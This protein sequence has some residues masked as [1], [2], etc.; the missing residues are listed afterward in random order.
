MNSNDWFQK[1]VDG[2]LPIESFYPVLRGRHAEDES[3]SSDIAIPISES[4]EARFIASIPEMNSYY[5]MNATG[6]EKLGLTREGLCEAAISNLWALFTAHRDTL[7]LGELLDESTEQP[8]GVWELQYAGVDDDATLVSG[9]LL[10]PQFL[11]G[12]MSLLID[13]AGWSASAVLAAAVP[14]RDTVLLCNV[15]GSPARA[16]TLERMRNLIRAQYDGG[17]ACDSKPVSDAIIA[18]EHTDHD[19]AWVTLRD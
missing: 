6:L 12:L 19:S 8:S 17:G 5:I 7:S 1:C 18:L 14:V 10:I 11:D 16:A 15:E 2:S 13:K 9:L 3:S 4:H